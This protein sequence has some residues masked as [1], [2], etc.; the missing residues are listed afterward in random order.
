MVTFMIKYYIIQRYWNGRWKS[1][2]CN[3]SSTR[4]HMLLLLHPTC[5]PSGKNQGF[6]LQ[7]PSF[8][9]N[10]CG[11]H[12]FSSSSNFLVNPLLTS[13]QVFILPII[14]NIGWVLEILVFLSWFVKMDTKL[15]FSLPYRTCLFFGEKRG[16]YAL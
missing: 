8:L 14:L 3:R 2:T 10:H 4:V 12:L 1:P 6:D 11:L 16:I 7:L 9:S 15:P 13:S 5:G